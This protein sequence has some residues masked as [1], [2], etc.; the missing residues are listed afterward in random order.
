MSFL[1]SLQALQKIHLKTIYGVWQELLHADSV[2]Q[3]EVALLG[4]LA[5]KILDILL[6]ATTLQPWTPPLS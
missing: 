6:M 3:L 4:T 2:Q 1:C 5:A